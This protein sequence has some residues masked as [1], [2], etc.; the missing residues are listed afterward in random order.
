MSQDL[1]YFTVSID[2]I[3][4]SA[5][6][7][8]F[9]DNLSANSYI[10]PGVGGTYDM[11]TGWPSDFAN[12]TARARGNLRWKAIL[13]QLAST[14]TPYAVSN[15]TATGATNTGEAT[16]MDFTVVYDRPDYLYAY[17]ELNAGVMLFND[18]AIARWIARALVQNI[19]VETYP[20]LDPT[21]FSSPNYH[22][23]ETLLPLNAAPLSPDIATAET[24]INVTFVADTSGTTF[25]P[26]V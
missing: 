11:A 20:V 18:H 23:G 10:V 22:Y 9:I 3:T 2:G 13:E 21:A 8:G 6:A 19:N 12:A 25:Y 17:D 15:I 26:L 4:G 1:L 5:P 7:D 14:V 16:S 24:K